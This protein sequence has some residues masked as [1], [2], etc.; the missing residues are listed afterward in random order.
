M[1]EQCDTHH[2]AISIIIPARNNATQLQACLQ[3]II[4]SSYS[5]YE[6]IVVDDGSTDETPIITQQFPVKIIQNTKSQGPA[7]ARNQGAAVASGEILFFIDSDIKIHPDTLAIISEA[8]NR[9]PEF[10]AI[11][12]YYDDD[13]SEPSFISQYKNLFHHY[14]HQNSNENAC[15]FW[16]GCGAI[17]RQVFLTIGGFNASYKRPAIE[18]IELGFR[19]IAQNYRVILLKQLQVKHLKR[20]TFWRLVKTEIFDRGIPWTILMLRHKIFPNDLNLQISQRI[21]VALVLALLISVIFLVLQLRISGTVFLLLFFLALISYQSFLI[22]P[23]QK[24]I[25][26]WSLIIYIFFTS[27]FLATLSD[28]L[29]L[30]P[31]IGIIGVLFLAV[32]LLLF[33]MQWL[34][35]RF[36]L[37]HKRY[38]LSICIGYPLALTILIGIYYQR[39][40]FVPILILFMLI[41]INQNF[42]KFFIKKRGIAFT[43]MAFPLHILYYLYCEISFI[44]GALSY[45]LG[46]KI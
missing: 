11:I 6:C 27:S 12:G 33:Q 15:T 42:Y 43:V 31:M 30:F 22:P 3:G 34:W 25:T 13:P 16:S 10:D 1:S 40:A 41:L 26:V 35:Y 23:Q 4:E 37:T 44:L 38:V 28:K 9:H 18:D 36:F 5:G 17:R 29:P 20:W 2:P 7:Q 19:L 39:L 32:L 46:R 21:S 14:V 24:A 8:F 45:L